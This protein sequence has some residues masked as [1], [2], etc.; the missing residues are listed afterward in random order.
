MVKEI[1]GQPE[2]YYRYKMVMPLVEKNSNAR[3]LD[4]GC[5]DGVF[6]IDVAK[7]IDTNYIFGTEI[8]EEEIKKARS[9]N[10]EVEYGDLNTKLPYKNNTFDVILANQVIE[11]LYNTD[12]FIKELFR[13]CKPGGYVIVATVNLA[14]TLN[15]LYLLF[16]KQPPATHVS[17]EV[18][19]GSPFINITNGKIIKGQSHIRVFTMKA[20]KGLLQYHGFKIEKCKSAG[21]YPFPKAIARMFSFIDRWHSAY[22][23]VKARKIEI[24]Y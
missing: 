13:V 14:S 2:H 23:V 20:L 9:N 4:C 15:I 8:I 5:G 21:Y 24:V 17:D 19:V 22:I 18:V 11:H 1:V 16:G 10:I 12:I 3:F 6:T 7:N